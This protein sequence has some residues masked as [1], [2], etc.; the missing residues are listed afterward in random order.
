MNNPR[1]GRPPQHIKKVKTMA[2]EQ[3][4]EIS[5]TDIQVGDIL[6]GRTHWGC[7][8]PHFYKVI[9]TKGKKTLVLR[10]MAQA[11]DSVYRSNGD[12][13]SMPA[14]CKDSRCPFDGFERE[15]IVEGRIYYDDCGCG[16]TVKVGAGRYVPYVGPWDGEPLAGN[17][18]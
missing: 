8:S 11:Y 5:Q 7:T 18:M 17:C 4:L 6:A 1:G 10:E 9:A 16:Y 15:E 2:R 12:Y 13:I 14:E 3:T